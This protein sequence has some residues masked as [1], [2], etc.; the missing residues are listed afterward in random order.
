[1]DSFELTEWMALYRLEPFGGDTPYIGHA[2]TAATVANANRG[3][4]KKGAKVEDFMPK[5]NHK[6]QTPEEQIQ[7]AAMMTAA[8]GGTIGGDNG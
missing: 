8:L 7:F 4:G 5:F 1:M 2:I 6:A 3:K